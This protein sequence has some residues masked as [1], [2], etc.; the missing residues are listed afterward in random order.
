MRL[1]DTTI[2]SGG[3]LTT[4]GQSDSVALLG[5]RVRRLHMTL[6]HKLT[7]GGESSYTS[8]TGYAILLFSASQ[9]LLQLSGEEAGQ[10]L[11]YAASHLTVLSLCSYDN[12][13]ARKLYIQLQIIYDDIREVVVSP[14]YRT[15]CELHVTI[16][17]AVLVQLSH[18]YAVKGVEEASKTILDIARSSI[19]VLQERIGPITEHA[20]LV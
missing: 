15:M 1:S 10:E 12:A 2:R 16:R 18:C 20:I 9:R 13:M 11:S 17:G 6:V 8:F 14:I 19:G 3:I 5:Y 4:D 7:Q